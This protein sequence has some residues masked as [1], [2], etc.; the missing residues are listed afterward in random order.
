MLLKIIQTI[1][2]SCLPSFKTSFCFY[3]LII[4]LYKFLISTLIHN[5]QFRKS[6]YPFIQIYLQL[7]INILISTVDLLQMAHEL[8]KSL[9][10]FSAILS[11]I[12][13]SVNLL[14][15]KLLSLSMHFA[16]SKS[17]S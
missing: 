2:I 10:S 12:V 7:H 6:K 1:S 17:M 3:C 14:N 13:S 5:L 4:I 8:I 15:L 9:A 11:L 16:P